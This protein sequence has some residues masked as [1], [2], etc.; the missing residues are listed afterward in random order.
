MWIAK[1]SRNGMTY[2]KKF[3]SIYDCQNYIDKELF[4]LEYLYQRIEVI[5]GSIKNTNKFN[6]YLDK[7]YPNG[8]PFA[9]RL[10]EIMIF[11][12]RPLKRE[13]QKAIKAAFNDKEYQP[14]TKIVA[15]KEYNSNNIIRCYYIEQKRYATGFDF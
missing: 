3:N 5:E 15:K 10:S 4:F 12:M 7:K 14:K 11:S 13:F 6:E 2:G 1:N 8:C 9:L